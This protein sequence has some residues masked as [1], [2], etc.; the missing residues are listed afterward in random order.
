MLCS[1][2]YFLPYGFDLIFTH[3]LCQVSLKKKKKLHSELLLK[4]DEKHRASSNA[5]IDQLLVIKLVDQLYFTW[6]LEQLQ[7]ILVLPGRY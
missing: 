3:L 1:T 5:V 6:S 4:M 2:L 7:L